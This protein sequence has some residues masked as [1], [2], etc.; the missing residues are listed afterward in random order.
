MDSLLY[1]SVDME[2]ALWNGKKISASEV[3]AEYSYEKQV[4]DVSSKELLC[5]DPNCANP[6]LRYC[7]GDK[8]DAYFAHICNEDCDYGDYDRDTPSQIKLVCKRL[9]THLASLGYNVQMEVKVLKHHYTHI[10]ITTDNNER[11]AIEFGN[12]R[13]SEKRIERITQEYKDEGISVHWIIVDK[14]DVPDGEDRV[15]CLKR[16]IL[17]ESPN[18]DLIIIEPETYKVGQYKIDEKRYWA[19]GREIY[20][21]NYPKTYT[22]ESALEN[23]IFEN[24]ELTLPEFI[25]SYNTWFEKKNKQFLKK[26]EQLEKE[27][28][29]ERKKREKEWNK[30]NEERAKRGP[31]F[32]YTP[33]KATD[34][35]PFLQPPKPILQ[36]PK[37]A[38][39][40]QLTYEERKAEIIDKISQTTEYAIDSSGMKWFKCERCGKVDE[41]PEFVSYGG[42]KKYTLGLCREC[43][44]KG[45]K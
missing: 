7:H 41:D 38:I 19:A 20:S 26:K 2:F 18:C 34:P 32:T 45:N 10:L 13:T 42:H 33:Y 17:N 12:Q 39:K 23:I 37:E 31:T 8:K 24:N 5:P 4:R 28:A 1:W 43:S 21:E 3:S 16:Y 25:A 15:Y 29:E 35:V 14:L 44:R 22:V 9:Y 30:K 11:V 36:Q 27:A 6:I 40:P